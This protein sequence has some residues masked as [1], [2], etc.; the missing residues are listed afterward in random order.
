MYATY[1]THAAATAALL[2]KGRGGRGTSRARAATLGG[3]ALAVTGAALGVAGMCRF[4]D[5]AHISG[6]AD[7]WLATGGV[8]SW[9]RNPQY[10]GYVAA[11]GGLAWARRSLP[12][13]ALAVGAAGAFA[14]WVR[15]EERHLSRVFGVPYR[16]YCARTSRWLGRSW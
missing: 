12:A 8:Y 2:V 9:S 1:T 10:L 4:A 5:T 6:M 16:R 7:E 14:W 11:L 13:A 3:Y 15:V